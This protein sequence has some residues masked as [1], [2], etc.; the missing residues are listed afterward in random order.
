MSNLYKLT[1]KFIATA[2]QAE[3]EK[4]NLLS[5]NQLET[6][7]RVQDAKEQALINIALNKKYD[8]NLKTTWIDVKK[9]F[10]SI[11]HEYLHICLKKLN[12]PL[13]IEKSIIQATQNF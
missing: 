4:R 5:E 3:I 2:L 11:D 12:L 1:T 7:R 6:V 9:A 8:N 13:W 10:D